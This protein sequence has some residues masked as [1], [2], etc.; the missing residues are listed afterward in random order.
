M[1]TGQPCFT[2]VKGDVG[3]VVHDIS[4]DAWQHLSF[5]AGKDNKMFGEDNLP[6]TTSLP[7]ENLSSQKEIQ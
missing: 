3:P 5:E 1:T 7:P 2:R 4:L 6:E